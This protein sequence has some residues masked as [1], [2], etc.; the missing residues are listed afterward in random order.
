MSLAWQEYDSTLENGTGFF[1]DEAHV[2]SVDGLSR[3]SIMDIHLDDYSESYWSLG[4][5]DTIANGSQWHIAGPVC[6]L[7]ASDDLSEC[8]VQSPRLEFLQ[9]QN[10]YQAEEEFS[11]RRQELN[12]SDTDIASTLDH[13]TN[14]AGTVSH[15]GFDGDLPPSAENKHERL[16]NSNETIAV[17]EAASYVDQSIEICDV[18][19]DAHYL[20]EKKDANDVQDT[21]ISNRESPETITERDASIPIKPETSIPRESADMS[22]TESVPKVSSRRKSTARSKTCRSTTPMVAGVLHKF[23]TWTS[24]VEDKRCEECQVTQTP[25]WRKN[26]KGS[27]LCNRCGIR[28]SRAASKLSLRHISDNTMYCNEHDTRTAKGEPGRSSTSLLLGYDTSSRAER[29]SRRRYM[30]SS[31]STTNADVLS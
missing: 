15:N 25:L 5:P 30:R 22:N 6:P 26:D 20:P 29:A 23:E 31:P 28:Y 9:I 7:S 21:L 27:P 19:E 14:S 24:E 8:P 11:L 2:A 18:G 17:P 1:W 10:S 13:A 4:T 16:S 3:T 12:L